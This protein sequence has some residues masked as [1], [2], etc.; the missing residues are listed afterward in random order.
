MEESIIYH[1]DVNNAFLSWSAHQYLLDDPDST[2]IRTVASVIGGSQE[3][4][5]G[6]VLAKS[7]LAK[8]YGIH[9]ADPLVRARE[10]CPNL[11]VLPPNYSL[12]AKR[13]RCFIELLKSVAP[14]VEQYSIDEAFCDMSGTRRI[15]GDPVTFAD[16]L[17]ER[18]CDE[19]GFTVNIGISTNKIL[20]KM[21]S[22]FHKPNRTNTLFPEEIP[23]KMWPLPVGE[24]FSVGQA[25]KKKLVTLGIYTIGDLAACD[26]KIL[27]S[28]FHKQ[29]EVIWNYANGREISFG[30][31]KEIA[32]KGYS[33]E[34][35]ISHD[36]TD[37][38]NAKMILLSLAETL[39]ERIRGDK[40]YIS[41]ISVTIVTNEFERSSHQQSLFSS[42]NITEEIYET[43]C[44]LFDELWKH[45]PIRQLGIATSK[46]TTDNS[47]QYSLFEQD[48]FERLSKLNSA[49]DDIRTRY[50]DESIKRACFLQGEEAFAKRG[51]SH[52]KSI[53]RKQAA[54]DKTP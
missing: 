52:A 24:L 11:L 2:D 43:A 23:T 30:S 18:I 15:Y 48:K 29:G 41:V 14:S 44:H 3:S 53:A 12:Y 22:E 20:A 17:R 54:E 46:A 33:N 49:I 6:I 9:T 4:R 1:V 39:G 13:S 51:L 45:E 5:R 16:T 8:K 27:I 26:K 10:M 32:N 47:H 50:G 21:A 34:T 19:M 7:P 35:T 42:T 38:S 40:S 25:T 37:A 31:S 36:V 28:H